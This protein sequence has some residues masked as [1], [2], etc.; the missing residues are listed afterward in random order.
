MFWLGF[1]RLYSSL[2]DTRPVLDKYNLEKN[3]SFQNRNNL[4]RETNTTPETG[5]KKQTAPS[6]QGKPK[7]TSTTKSKQARKNAEGEKEI[8]HP[9]HFWIWKRQRRQNSAMQETHSHHS[10]GHQSQRC[11]VRK[12]SGCTRS[13]STLQTPKLWARHT[14]HSPQPYPRQL[15]NL[16]PSRPP[17]APTPR[18]PPTN[19]HSHPQQPPTGS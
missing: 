8:A 10:V 17:T 3:T 7:T 5:T 14:P 12:A 6:K 9:E 11:W 18:Q 13:A 16:T 1:S 2:T 19:K 15:A 4:K